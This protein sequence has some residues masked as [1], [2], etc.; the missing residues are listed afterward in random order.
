M[1]L[2]RSATRAIEKARLS[3]SRSLNEK[4]FLN[5]AAPP[6]DIA[7]R[8]ERVFAHLGEIT[9]R[10]PADA[11]REAV[12]PLLAGDVRVQVE[13]VDERRPEDQDRS[14]RSSETDTALPFGAIAI[15]ES[16]TDGR[17]GV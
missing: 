10:C 7:S 4:I 16:A 5:C 14:Q 8:P 11:A 17:F 15:P 3:I 12:K 1:N 6:A 13:F 2:S 9:D